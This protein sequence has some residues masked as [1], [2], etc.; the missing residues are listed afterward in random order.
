ML[1]PG[2]KLVQG[3]TEAARW[4]RELCIPFQ[5]GLSAGAD[6]AVGKSN[7]VEVADPADRV[8]TGRRHVYLNPKQPMAGSC[9][10]GTSSLHYCRRQ[11]VSVHGRERH[12]R[13]HRAAG[14]DSS[15]QQ[16]GQH[17]YYDLR[18]AG[19]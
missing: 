6:R 8:Q 19:W 12:N 17:A 5:R 10:G 18:D 16:R 13:H 14:L 4:S 1:Y 11:S 15:R 9:I 7:Q 2:M 3:S